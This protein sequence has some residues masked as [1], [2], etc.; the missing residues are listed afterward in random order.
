MKYIINVL[1][2]IDVLDE[3]GQIPANY[4]PDEQLDCLF[5]KTTNDVIAWQL[6]EPFEEG[7]EE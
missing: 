2:I 7:D 6:V 4:S 5:N 3:H 1:A